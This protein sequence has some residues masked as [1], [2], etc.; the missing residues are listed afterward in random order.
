M[1][2]D[3]KDLWRS[4]C[5]TSLLKQNH[6]M[7]VALQCVHMATEYLQG[8]QLQHFHGQLVPVLYHPHSE[9]VFSDVQKAVLSFNVCPLPP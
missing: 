3:G 2:E 4:S 6:L 7:Q 9:S 8:V 5:T 1:A